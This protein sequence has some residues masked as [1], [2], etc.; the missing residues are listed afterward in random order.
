MAMYKR[1]PH[2]VKTNTYNS[3]SLSN[4]KDTKIQRKKNISFCFVEI[5]GTA[6]DQIEKRN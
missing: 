6:V 5:I 2:T 4:E 3:L 1:Q